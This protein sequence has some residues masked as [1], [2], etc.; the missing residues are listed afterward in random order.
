LFGEV[1]IKGKEVLNTKL[2][3]SG[4][5]ATIHQAQAS[6]VGKQ[7]GLNGSFVQIGINPNYAQE[8]K[9]AL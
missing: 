9:I 3:R 7:E 6:A 4:H 1:L 8:W 5:A 2:V